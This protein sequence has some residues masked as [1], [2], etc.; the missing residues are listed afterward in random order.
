MIAFHAA[1]LKGINL[2]VPCHLSLQ[3][4]IQTSLRPAKRLRGA[5]ARSESFHAGPLIRR[6]GITPNIL[7]NGF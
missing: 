2:S 4:E 5:A 6:I 7:A 3:G 1:R